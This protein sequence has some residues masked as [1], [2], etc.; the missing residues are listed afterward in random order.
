VTA[1]TVA[2]GLNMATVLAI[3]PESVTTMINLI[4]NLCDNPTAIDAVPLS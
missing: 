4:F 3:L 2:N 1:N